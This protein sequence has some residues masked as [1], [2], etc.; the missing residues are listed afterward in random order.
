MTSTLAGSQA[1]SEIRPR[2]DKASAEVKAPG[3]VIIVSVK[4]GWGKMVFTTA[5]NCRSSKVGILGVEEEGFFG[6][7]QG[8]RL[9]RQLSQKRR[10]W[11]LPEVGE[12]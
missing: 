4:G 6:A 3:V 8:K 7:V 9:V 11:D 1:L 5:R 2:T 12:S 10:W